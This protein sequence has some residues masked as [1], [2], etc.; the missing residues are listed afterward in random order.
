MIAEVYYGMGLHTKQVDA[1]NKVKAFLVRTLQRHQEFELIMILS[2]FGS[3]N[4][5]TNSPMA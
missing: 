5:Y 1:D 2:G 4:S 3:P